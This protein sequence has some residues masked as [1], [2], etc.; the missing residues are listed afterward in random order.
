MNTPTIKVLVISIE[1]QKDRRLH[2]S[3]ILND[4]GIDWEFVDAVIGKNLESFP[5]QYDHTKRMRHFGFHISWGLLGCFLSHRKAWERCIELNQIC[6]ILEDDAKPLPE[7][8]GSL[9]IALSIK[10][11]WD[12]FR[13][14]GIY[15]MNHLTLHQRDSFKIIEHL[16][17]PSS[18]AAFLVKPHAAKKLLTHSEKFYVPNDDFIERSYLHKLRILAIKPYPIAIEHELPTTITDRFKPK[19]S[20]KKRLLKELYKTKDGF[21]KSLWRLKRRLLHKKIF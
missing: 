19:L 2:I 18:A 4:L 5:P 21:S 15:E 1:N 6:L 7:L 17:D 13:L 3:Q 11:H 10:E 16:K 9:E 12:L 8:T 14:H 20:I